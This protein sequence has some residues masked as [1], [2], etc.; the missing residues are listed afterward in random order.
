MLKTARLICVLLTAVSLTT[1]AET[2]FADEPR[3]ILIKVLIDTMQYEGRDQY[4]LVVSS[5]NASSA[6]VVVRIVEQGFFI[7]TD[8]GWTRLKMNPREGESGEFLLPGAGNK[9]RSASIRIPLAVPDLF[10]TYEGDLSLMYKYTYS[11]RTA[12][13]TGSL[14]EKTDEVYCWVKPRTSQW[15]LREGM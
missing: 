6:D 11:V 2:A 13:R 1:F 3:G 12:D 9:K 15:I 10:K 8:H 14:F 7:Q 4:S 5:S